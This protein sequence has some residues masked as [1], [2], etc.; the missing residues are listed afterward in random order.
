[1][2][3]DLGYLPLI[4]KATRITYHTSTL[5]DHIY[6][7]TPEKIIKSGI[8]LAD[9]SD[10]LPIFCTLANTMPSSNDPKYF[11]DFSNFS[12]EHFLE[13]ISHID[14]MGLITEDVNKS[15]N[16]MVEK[17]RLISNKHAPLRKAS[18]QKRRQLKKP[19]LFLY[20][21]KKT[22]AFQIP[23]LKQ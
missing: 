14:F 5:I 12:K 3:L 4:T 19:S 18:K 20:Q 2:L 7:N 1:M 6:T 21:L 10:H 23:L 11:R 16:N 15:M 22:K 17:L 9:I 13:E 8:C